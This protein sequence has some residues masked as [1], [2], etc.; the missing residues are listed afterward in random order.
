[1][2]KFRISGL[3]AAAAIA[4]LTL[5][6]CS[7][8][9][10]D[11]GS[12]KADAAPATEGLT[13]VVVGV[14]PI[15]P[16]SAVQLGID[17]GVFE[18]HGLD[19]ELQLGDGGAALLPAVASGT[20]QFAVG[21]PLSVLTAAS[22]GLDMKIVSNYSLNYAD[23]SDPEDKAPSGITTRA[24]ANIKSWKDLEGKT[25]AINAL[26]TQ[27]DLGTKEF[28]EADG[29][30]P[31]KVKFIEV[32]FP[33]Q[34]AQLEQGNI[35]ASWTPEP[36]L[37]KARATEGV[38]FL[39]DPLRAI[40]N[41]PTMVTFTSGKFAAENP[42]TVSAFRDAIAE[43]AELAMADEDA[44]RAA[45]VKHTNMPE[46]VVANINLEYITGTLDPAVLKE[47]SATA[48]KFG[49]IETEPNLDEVIISE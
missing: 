5:S 49:F 43:T 26:N 9:S 27:G 31:S 40:D 10:L 42:E 24:D 15:A 35:D 16:A 32:P 3:A 39:G 29:G 34:L 45:V 6:A 17:E 22:Q 2:K 44:F 36:F 4:A 46:D 1:M 7:G 33:D 28:V 21:N 25:L 20:M 12:D 41:L 19:V 47:L 13:K 8:G 48:M 30:D 38:E 18:K 14:L 11:G 23:P 37:S